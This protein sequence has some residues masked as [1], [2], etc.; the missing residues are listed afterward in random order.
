MN[1][2]HRTNRPLVF[3]NRAD[4]HTFVMGNNSQAVSMNVPVIPPRISIASPTSSL[5]NRYYRNGLMLKDCDD[6]DLQTIG[7]NL[8]MS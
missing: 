2:S 3:S 4:I 6:R 8:V 5:F 1:N 7:R